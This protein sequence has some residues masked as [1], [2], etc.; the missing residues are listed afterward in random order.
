MMAELLNDR[1]IQV[2][3]HA[4]RTKEARLFSSFEYGEELNFSLV[5]GDFTPP[6]NA[7][8]QLI[9]DEDG[10]E[11]YVQGTKIEN[12]FDFS[13]NTVQICREN[14]KRGLFYYLFFLDNRVLSQNEFGFGMYIS[15][16]DQ[17]CS[18]FQ[19]SIYQPDLSGPI[20]QKQPIVYKE[21][22]ST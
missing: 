11:L 12:R 21:R 9:R 2:K 15:D 17:S 18:R 7:V 13:I 5:F 1:Q 16:Y 10:E 22:R 20:L 14:E 19:L 3:L 8:M 4:S 6:K